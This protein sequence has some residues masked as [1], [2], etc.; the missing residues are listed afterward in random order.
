VSAARR[1]PRDERRRRLGQN[2]LEEDPADLF[3]SDADIAPGELIV[4]MGAG[5]GALSRRLIRRGAQV[6]AVEADPVWAERLRE[7][8]RR[9]GQGRLQVV[10]GDFLRWPLPTRPYR[11]VACLPF[12]ATT[13]ILRRADLIVEWE[14][15]RKRGASPPATLLSTGW[16]PWWE[17][18]QGRR[19]PA[20]EF[21]R[22]QWPFS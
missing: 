11:V 8:A 2:F 6:I 10:N 7:L 18:R 22:R 12:G 4:D 21:V 14:V 15:A 1:T 20:A 3:V 13:A 17:F 19:I 16:A 5:S 9:E